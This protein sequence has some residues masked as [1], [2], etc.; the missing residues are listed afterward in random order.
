M[1]NMATLW[2]QQCITID[3]KHVH[4]RHRKRTHRGHFGVFSSQLTNATI[5]IHI[6]IHQCR[7]RYDQRIKKS[8]T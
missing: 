1:A 3:E 4:S 6:Q 5:I 2:A 8:S 7:Q